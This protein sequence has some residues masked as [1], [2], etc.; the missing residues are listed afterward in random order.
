MVAALNGDVDNHADLRAGPRCPSP[1]RSPPTPR[2]SRRWCP[3]RPLTAPDLT[4][5]FR[6][7]VSAFEG[8]VAIA[9]ASAADPGQVLLALR[10]SGQGLYVGLAEDLTIVASEPYG[11]VEVTDSYLRM[12]GEAPAHAD[13]PLSRGQVVV[14]SARLGRVGSTA[15]SAAPTTARR[16]PSGRTSWCGPR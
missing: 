3:A 4:E 15:S 14:L 2:S 11:L 16:C 9:A 7:T 6:R 5:A 1:R 8:S 10:G 13:Q 12:D